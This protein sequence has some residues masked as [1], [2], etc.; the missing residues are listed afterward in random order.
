MI[1]KKLTKFLQ[2]RWAIRLQWLILAVVFGIALIIAILGVTGQLQRFMQKSH[3]IYWVKI[4]AGDFQM[5]STDLEPNAH[6]DEFPQHRVYLDSYY[7]S[8]NLITNQQYAQCVLVGV[9]EKPSSTIIDPEEA[10]HPVV[11]VA[12]EDAQAFCNWNGA[13]LPTEAEWENAARGR[14]VGALYPWGDVIDCTL[15]NYGDCVGGRNPV[16]SYAP[17][18][19]GLYDM[20]G[21]VWEWVAD[22]YSGEYY[23]N[24]PDD[25]PGGPANGEYRVLRGGCWGENASSMRAAHRQFNLPAY[26]HDFIGFRC[27]YSAV[28]WRR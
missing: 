2:A 27:T 22:W 23:R 19:Y 18:G 3:P 20:A 25:N 6:F 17:N 11:N 24:S 5:G 16:G 13:R 28:L 10:D 21:N 9:C 26:P 7:I 1:Q 4:P 12:W 8:R 14:L 15:A